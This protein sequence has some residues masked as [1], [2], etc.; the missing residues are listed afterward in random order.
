MFVMPIMII[1]IFVKKIIFTGFMG[2]GKS[3]IGKLLSEKINW[4]F[5]DIDEKITEYYKKSINDIFIEEG[6][7]KFK[8]MEYNITEKYIKNDEKLIISLGSGAVENQK[9]FDI[10]NNK[11]CKCIYLLLDLETCL[12]RCKNTDRPLLLN[13][14]NKIINKYK[15]RTPIYMKIAD[16][17]IYGNKNKELII[18]DIINYLFQ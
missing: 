15:I 11:Y 16:L 4:N 17:T 6:E 12:K 10:I 1:L 7:L 2:S 13:N 5:I 14:E 3:T 9:L 8:E 18:D